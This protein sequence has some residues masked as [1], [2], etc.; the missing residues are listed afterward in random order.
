MLGV[1]RDAPV[2]GR[3]AGPA[4]QPRGLREERRLPGDV[5]V[6]RPDEVGV[7]H[8]LRATGRRAPVAVRRNRSSRVGSAAGTVRR[9]PTSPESISSAAAM[10]VMSEIWAF[11]PSTGNGAR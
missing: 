4:Q 11:Q 3:V 9:I 7:G 10:P 8:L 1:L 6:E 2:E 5:R